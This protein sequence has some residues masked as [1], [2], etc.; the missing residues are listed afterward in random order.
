VNRG[1]LRIVAASQSFTIGEVLSKTCVFLARSD[2]PR[3]IGERVILVRHDVDA[4][5]YRVEIRWFVVGSLTPYATSE[6]G[7]GQGWT[8]DDAANVATGALIATIGRTL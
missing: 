5:E 1:A 8:A 4:A 3:G 6:L 2:S 7:R